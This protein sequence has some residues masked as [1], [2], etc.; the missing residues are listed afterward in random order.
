M[1]AEDKVSNKAKELK[2]KAKKA[3]ARVT[4]DE[5]LMAEGRLDEAEAKVRKVA[6]KAK[7]AIKRR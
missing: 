3:V 4:G 1:G 2:G 6:E 7:D 5:S